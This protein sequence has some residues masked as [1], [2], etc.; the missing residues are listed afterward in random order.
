MWEI[1][2]GRKI[3]TD[4]SADE[5]NSTNAPIAAMQAAKPD[6]GKE[7]MGLTTRL[8]NIATSIT[9]ATTSIDGDKIKMPAPSGNI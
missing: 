1:I 4:G 8:S 3:W 5:A 9:N 7:N 2:G 6:D